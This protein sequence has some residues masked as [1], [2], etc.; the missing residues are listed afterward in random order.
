MVFLAEIR[1]LGTRG[2]GLPGWMGVD[3][4][5]PAPFGQRLGTIATAFGAPVDVS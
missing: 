3:R 2:P 4:H 1:P 5:L